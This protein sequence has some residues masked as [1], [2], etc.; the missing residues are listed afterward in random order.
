M[1]LQEGSRGS[2]VRRLQI[3]LNDRVVPRPRLRVDGSFGA[4]TRAAVEAFQSAKRL[5]VDGIVGERTWAALGQRPTPPVSPTPPDAIGAP[6]LNVA[7]AELGVRENSLPG[8]HTQRILD[9]HATTTLK[10]TTDETPWCSSFVNWAM[11][12]ANLAGTNSAAAKSWMNW[13]QKLDVPRTGAVVVI[14]RKNASS[15]SSTGSTTGFHV[16]FYISSSPDSLRI[17]GGNQ[18]N[19]VRYSNFSLDEWEVQG[20]Y[21]P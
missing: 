18:R 16:G 21:W 13:G 12:Q 17:F 4:R 7:Q 20:Y 1:S 10:A 3:L 19:Q 9:Y 14:K 8:Q 15:D 2:D 11:T 6:W 5:K